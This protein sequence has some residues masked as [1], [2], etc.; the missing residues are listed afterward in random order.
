MA[1]AVLPTPRSAAVPAGEIAIPR[2]LLLRS[3]ARYAGAAAAVTLAWLACLAVSTRIEVEPAL[4]EQALFLHL[5]AIIAGM[6]AVLTLDW[7]A[8]RWLLGTLPLRSLLSTAAECH[9]VIWTGWAV[10]VLTGAFLEPDLSRT[11]TQVKVVAVLVAGLNGLAAHA[12][13]RR[14]EGAEVVGLRLLLVAGSVATV[15]QA[16]WWTAVVVGFLNAR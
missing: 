12:M 7:L 3:L 14:L 8:L 16:A 10:L 15:S 9:L 1:H 2:I 11:L 4:H 6:G 13:Q 5:I